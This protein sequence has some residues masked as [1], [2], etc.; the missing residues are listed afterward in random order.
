MVE[1]V[2]ADLTSSAEVSHTL[3][4]FFFIIVLLA[5]LSNELLNFHL[6]AITVAKA[7]LLLEIVD[8]R[9]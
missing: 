7:K 6:G 4:P 8:H 3:S 9:V 1:I 5:Y 2:Y